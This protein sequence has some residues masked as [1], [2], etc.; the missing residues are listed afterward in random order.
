MIE[1]DHMK[2]CKDCIW[3]RRNLLG[4]L[5]ANEEQKC[6]RPGLSKDMVTGKVGYKP[7]SLERDYTPAYGCGWDAQYWEAK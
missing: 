6:V 4:R 2:L 5:I 1:Q 3:Y 7:C